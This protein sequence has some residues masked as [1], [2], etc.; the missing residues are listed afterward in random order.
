VSAVAVD[1]IG[2]IQ[3]PFPSPK[4]VEEDEE[5]FI[6]GAG[7]PKKQ[8][9]KVVH[10]MSKE[11]RVSG[12]V[13]MKIYGAYAK[14]VQNPLLIIMLGLC[15]ALGNGSQL[16]QQ[17]VVALWT[18]D[19]GYKRHTL[20]FYL[21]GVASMAA[22][23]GGFSYLRA[24]FGVMMGVAASRE[25]HSQMIDRVIAAPLSFFGTFVLYLCRF[26]CYFSGCAC[27]Y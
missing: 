12:A 14:A 1:S 22:L 20:P 10:L 3:I 2:S 7:L 6:V 17:W 8:P 16:L 9:K 27:D 15:V 5:D 21:T 24:Y 11:E 26:A 18:S 13:S 25:L 19:V 4:D 23:V